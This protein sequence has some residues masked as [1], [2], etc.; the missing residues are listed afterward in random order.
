MNRSRFGPRTLTALLGTVAI[1]VAA[2]GG[3]TATT[4]P[5][6]TAAASAAAVES[7]TPPPAVT[8][9]SPRAGAP[10]PNGGTVVSWFI[11]LG[12]GT[13]PAQTPGEARSSTRTT[14]R[15][16]TSTIALRSE[17]QRRPRNILKTEHRGRRRARHH[18]AGRRRGPQ[19]LRRSAARL[20]PLIASTSY[21]DRR[22]P[23]RW[24][25]SSTLGAERRHVGLPVRGLPV[26][27]LLQQG[28][29]RRGR[30]CPTRRRRSVTCTTASRGTWTRSAPSP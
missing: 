27:H 4:A 23:N 20:A 9:P 21:S 18:R 2:C 15:R 3:S 30:T 17:Q 13:Q 24:S 25:T 8:P 28:P 11:G 22:R 1:V 6:A 26:V 10:G 14:R 5:S 16:R 29:L 12:A 7:A 19:P